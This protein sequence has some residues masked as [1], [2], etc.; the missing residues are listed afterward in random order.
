[1]KFYFHLLSIL[2]I[3]IAA[4]P[5]MVSHRSTN[6]KPVQEGV[7]KVV[8]EQD[9]V[10][11]INVAHGTVESSQEFGL[12]LRKRQSPICT[13]ACGKVDA[14][15][16]LSTLAIAE[17]AAELAGDT[18]FCAFKETRTFGSKCVISFAGS[19]PKVET[20]V[21][22]ANLFALAEEVF[23]QCIRNP[24]D[25]IGGCIDSGDGGQVCLVK[26]ICA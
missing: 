13:E 16:C 14:N 25:A 19:D 6:I 22:N 7:A 18:L 3:N 4:T 12:R 24:N 5:T 8:G 10:R 2:P 11:G 17:K 20:C 1:M 23:N 21:T 15:D 26:N 9:G